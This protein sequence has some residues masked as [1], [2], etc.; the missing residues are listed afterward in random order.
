MFLLLFS[1]VLLPSAHAAPH[2]D[3][4]VKSVGTVHYA[5]NGYDENFPYGEVDVPGSG[6][7]GGTEAT[8]GTENDGTVHHGEVTCTGTITIGYTWNDDGD[9]N[10]L[11]PPMVYV[12]ETSSADWFGGSPDAGPIHGSCH[13]G[14][15]HEQSFSSPQYS[16]VSGSR[17]TIIN[18]PGMYF[19]RSCSPSA[20]VYGGGGAPPNSP[21]GFIDAEV[22]YGVAVTEIRVNLAGVTQ[23]GSQ[24]LVLTGQLVTA[25]LVGAQLVNW[26]V[27]GAVFNFFKSTSPT[28][29]NPC[30]EKGFTTADFSALNFDFFTKDEDIVEVYAVADVQTPYETFHLNV[31]AD[32]IHSHKPTTLWKVTSQITQFDVGGYGPVLDP[33]AFGPSDEAAHNDGQEWKVDVTVPPPFSGGDGCFSQNVTTARFAYYIGATQPPY[34]QVDPYNGIEGLDVGFPYQDII[35]SVPNPGLAGDSPQQSVRRP[36]KK[37]MATDSMATW[38]MYKPT[39]SPTSRVPSSSW[40]PL[41]NYTWGWSGEAN[42]LLDASTHQATGMWS[43]TSHLGAFPY[44]LPTDTIDFPSWNVVIPPGVLVDD[45]VYTPTP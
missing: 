20:E 30:G 41:Q 7:G 44:R 21:S 27:S 18:N 28:P 19:E 35:W 45:T 2:Y 32:P 11:P 12:Q 8:F 43:L 31:P 13:S 16:Y 26:N 36:F 22:Y 39:A 10:N 37:V 9:P 1:S 34:R 40:I 6:S 4:V 15:D 25:S 23:Q 5:F 24:K 14:L 3:A 33:G 38:A 29:A 42:Q 17:Y